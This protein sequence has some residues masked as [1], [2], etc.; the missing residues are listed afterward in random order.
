MSYPHYDSV[1]SLGN[2]STR[3]ARVVDG[4]WQMTKRLYDNIG[5]HC[6]V[7]AKH[8]TQLEKRQ[9]ASCLGNAEQITR[10]DPTRHKY[11]VALKEYFHQQAGNLSR[12]SLWFYQ[13]PQAWPDDIGCSPPKGLSG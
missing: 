13:T 6:Q 4:G 1:V 9:L 2:A 7:V 11:I 12:S 3:L 5:H 8:G 10:G